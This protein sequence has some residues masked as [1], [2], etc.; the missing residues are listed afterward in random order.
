MNQAP[1][2]NPGWA[3]ARRLVLLSAAAFA[4]F[5]LVYLLAVQTEL[6]QRAD[7]AALTGGRQAPERAQDA[8]SELLHVVSIGSLL[9]ATA[10]LSALAWVRR[11]PGLLLIPAAVIGL[12]LLATEAFK[13]VIFERPE[14]VV[15]P[16]LLSNSY[17]SGHTTVAVAIGLAAVLVAPPRLRTVVG[18]AAAALAGLAGVFVVTADWHRPSDPI[19]SYLLTLSVAAACMAALRLWLPAQ[20]TRTHELPSVR[21]GAA[22]LELTAMFAGASVFVGALVIGSLRYG[23]QVDWNRFHA[24][25]LFGSALIVIAAGLVVAALLRALELRAGL[26]PRQSRLA[27]WPPSQ[28]RHEVAA[29]AR[30]TQEWRADERGAFEDGRDGDGGAGQLGGREPIGA[31]R[32]GDRARRAGQRRAQRR[33]PP[34]L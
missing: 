14:L 12:S 15:A 34:A 1:T 8:A 22:K 6:G 28:E 31:G 16:K 24:T 11:R 20:T 33:D 18:F 2:A 17:P 30:S 10:F 32:G 19:G 5:L 13:L 4:A 27:S 9:A 25:F 3:S 23:A 26:G 21:R 29:G 7:E